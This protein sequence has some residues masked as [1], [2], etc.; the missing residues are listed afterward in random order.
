VILSSIDIGTNTVLLLIAEVNEDGTIK[1]LFHAQRL[2]RLG[3]G[4]DS[5]RRLTA[6]SMERVIGILREYR[7]QV[8]EH[9]AASTIVCGTSAVRDAANREEFALRV[10]RETGFTLEVLTGQMEALW[11][12][13]GAVSGV[14]GLRAALVV[15]IGGGS[16]EFA[17]GNER[18]LHASRS[19]DTGSVRLSERFFLHDP[20]APEEIEQARASVRREIPA[21]EVPPGATFVGV[22]GTATAL[23]VLA[24][25][26]KEFRISAVTNYPLAR[27][28]VDQLFSRLSALP[29][30][31]IRELSAVMEGRADVITAGALILQEV[32][33]HFACHEILVSE[34]GLRYGLL[35]REWERL[36]PKD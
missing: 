33:R 15:D 13:R 7:R 2:P 16:T 3:R 22:A 11:G 19:V 5:S 23:A 36:R 24:Q 18:L 17:A 25:G 27:P 6:E 28:L 34:R 29:S 9:G 1:P 31:A 26:L 14:P 8:Q 20:P 30:R 12:Y 21:I 35:V 32:M 4:V 10:F